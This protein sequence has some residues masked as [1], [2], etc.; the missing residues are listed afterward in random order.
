MYNLR[1][2]RNLC[3]LSERRRVERKERPEKEKQGQHYYA[4]ARLV[5]WLLVAVQP[6][7]GQGPVCAR[8]TPETEHGVCN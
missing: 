1:G 5:M 3:G 8:K 7:V 6:L 4:K 2:S